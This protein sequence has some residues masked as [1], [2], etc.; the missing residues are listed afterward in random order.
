MKTVHNACKTW[1]VIY[2]TG[3]TDNFQWHKALPVLSREEADTQKAVL[4]RQGYI[5]LIHRT[6]LLEAIG[7][8]DTF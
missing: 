7:L 2:R 1:T 3:G 5:A 6:D 8:P 4:T